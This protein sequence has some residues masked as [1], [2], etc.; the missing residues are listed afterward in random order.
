MMCDCVVA[1]LCNRHCSGVIFK[2]SHGN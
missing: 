1:N 2:V